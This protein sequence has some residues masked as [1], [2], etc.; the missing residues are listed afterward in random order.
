MLHV[1]KKNATVF[2][3][4]IQSLYFFISAM[5]YCYAS[6]Y[7]LHRGLSNSQIG[8]AL[9]VSCI[10]SALLQPAAAILVERTGVRLGSFMA[11]MYVAFT[12][13]A[14]VLLLLPLQGTGL[15]VVMVVVFLI[16]STMQS[17]LN[18]LHVGQ[19]KDGITINYS[20]ARGVGSA[21]FSLS[22]F[23]VGRILVRISVDYLPGFYLVAAVLLIGMLLLF[24]DFR[25][26]GENPKT[27]TPEQ[28][29]LLLRKYPYFYLFLAG[30]TC[31]SITHTFTENYL[32]QTIQR[33]GGTS[34]NLGTAFA[35]A[36][37]T[38]LPAM[39]LYSKLYK[40]VGNRRLLCFAGWM[41]AT[42][43]FLIMIA[44]NIYVVYAAELLQFASYAI[45]V[46][47]AVRYISHAIPKS[48]FLKGQSLAGSAFTVGSIFSSFVGGHLIDSIGITQTLWLVQIFSVAGVLLFT[49]AMFG[50]LHKTPYVD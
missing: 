44:S 49:A 12:L 1:N 20:L 23:F 15:I 30:L 24:R 19:S 16:Q 36:A 40:K 11:L 14:L 27:V 29:A 13:A 22:N 46:P 10:L 25:T 42:K 50:S 37:I 39:L 18:C 21:V 38:E 5:V 8:I 48:E 3:T 28:K 9:G 43:N 2:Y 26:E 4:I 33:F 17:F 41:W 6:A 45:Y 7:L 34:A 47:A 32:L 31:L 35:I